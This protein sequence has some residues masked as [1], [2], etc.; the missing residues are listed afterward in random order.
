[1]IRSAPSLLPHHN[2]PRQPGDV[3]PFVIM[4]SVRPHLSGYPRISLL[5]TALCFCLLVN[6]AQALAQ[7]DPT[8]FPEYKVIAANVAF[9]EKVYS[10]YSKNTAII[11]D[12]QDL[13][14]VYNTV[15]L[16]EEG[17]PNSRAHNSRK[18]EQVKDH[19]RS[20]L[21]QLA[22]NPHPKNKEQRRIAALFGNATDASVYRRAADNI[23]AQT[24]L[25]EQF[26]EGVVRSGAYLQELRRI[27]KSY[28]LPEDLAYLPHVESSFN[29]KAFSK[30]GA[31]G[32]W[33]FTHTTGKEFLTIDY[34]IDERRDPII[35]AHA[36]ARFLERNH[37]QLGTWPLAL[38]AYNYGPAGM[39][40][41]LNQEGNYQNIFKNYQKGYFKFASRN[42]YSEFLAAV[43]AAKKL[44]RSG[45]VLEQPLRAVTVKLPAYARADRLC[46]YLDINTEILRK[47][48]PALRDPV[49]KG[50][51]YIPKNYVL[52]LPYSFNNSKLLAAAPSSIFSSEQKR[53]IF[54]RVRPGDSAGAIAQAHKISLKSLI[55]AN[56][57][58]SDAVIRVGQNLRIP[59][60][61]QTSEIYQAAAVS[62]SEIP[63]LKD[64][65]KLPPAGASAPK[66][67]QNLAVSGNLK[68]VNQRSRNNLLVGTIEV[69]PDESIRLLADWLKVTPN[70]IRV[71]NNL[72]MNS[73]IYPG[74]MINLD[75]INTKIAAFEENRFDFHQ[76]LQEDFFSSYQ[77]VGF[78]S[79]RVE[80]GDTIWDL[81]RKKFGV[82]LWLLKK[83]NE[84]LDYNRLELA[85]SLQIPLLKEI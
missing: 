65:S 70:S 32:M 80:N 69:Q 57:L 14:I 44:E 33:Q 2:R 66:F 26:T 24:G 42:F 83:Y 8:H 82:P 64:N 31:A 59:A 84:S 23:R 35:S 43:K 34:I 62:F 21:L 58:N 74:Q 67:E 36:A 53:S 28:R 73:D 9:W 45:L 60:T 19:I 76:E 72:S 30:F 71:A 3:F 17:F 51:K 37:R 13:A 77:V 12:Q 15:S 29:P 5:I 39:Q 10:T 81:S 25:K 68:V 54:Y 7:A 20:V 22:K 48:N 40:R 52:K 16:L 63:V 49:F 18:I 11:H 61:V 55:Q 41:A 50:T 78:T 27:F 4:T 56:N 38:T 85:S 47:Y 79:Y 1:M 75:F 46:D 6:A